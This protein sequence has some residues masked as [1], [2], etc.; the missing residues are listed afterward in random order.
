MHMNNLLN[1]WNEITGISEVAVSPEPGS[2]TLLSECTDTYCQAERRN[3]LHT[4]VCKLHFWED[5]SAELIG[6]GF[7]SKVFK[8]M[9]NTTRKVMVVKVYKNDVDQE[10][11]I[12]EISLLQKLSHP[13]VVRYLGI[14]VREDKLYPVLEYVNGGCLEELLAGSDIT[15]CW[16]EKV[17]LACDICRGMSYLHSRNIYHRDLNSKNCLIRVTAQVRE[18]VVTDFGLA[19]EVVELPVNSSDRK[20][21][22]VGSAFW[23][24]PEMLR[25]EPYDRKVDVFSFG[26]MLCEI[27]ARIPAD[28]E[29]LPRTQDYGLDVEAFSELVEGCPEKILAL[30]A[31]C[32][33]MDAYRRPSFSDLLEMLEDV[34]ESLEPPD[35]SLT[36]G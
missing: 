8:V 36:S 29:V 13:N 12:R 3:R 30:S 18:A 9:H 22:L 7:F 5:F 19:R 2:P 27:L 17:E 24:A 10:S 32:C 21:S 23:M 14:C 34:A 1:C 31:N 28:P 16:R 26:I 4:H 33:Q 6:S 11:I 20:M 35:C 15:L 25:G